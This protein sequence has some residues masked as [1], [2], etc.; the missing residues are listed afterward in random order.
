MDDQHEIDVD[1]FGPLTYPSAPDPL[2]VAVAEAAAAQV[3]A[4]QPP[5]KAQPRSP[6]PPAS[7]PM[8]LAIIWPSR[9]GG[10]GHVVVFT[11]EGPECHVC[12]AG[13]NN[14]RCWATKTAAE[15]INERVVRFSREIP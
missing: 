6:R 14:N 13:Q 3:A 8:P 12:E 15:I 7:I 11:D 2:Q 1:A 9:T 10:T 4:L 5:P